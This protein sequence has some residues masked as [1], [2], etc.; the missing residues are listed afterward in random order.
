MNRMRCPCDGRRVCAFACV[1]ILIRGGACG[2]R[3]AMAR[4][5]HGSTALIRAAATGH[6]E[7]VRLLLEAGADKDAACKVRGR[8]DLVMRVLFFGGVLMVLSR[9]M[10]F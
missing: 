10:L 2:R 5:Q 9:H 3:G 1:D 6:V 7:C 8:F 4:A